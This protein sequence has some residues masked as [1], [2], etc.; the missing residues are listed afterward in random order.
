MDHDDDETRLVLVLV[1]YS[2]GRVPPIGSAI[3]ALFEKYIDKRDAGTV[4][5]THR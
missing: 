1:S 4:I 2:I 5:L 3:Q